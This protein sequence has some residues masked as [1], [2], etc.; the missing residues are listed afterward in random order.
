MA[1]LHAAMAWHCETYQRSLLCRER[2]QRCNARRYKHRE[3]RRML[4]RIWRNDIVD[5]RRAAQRL[6]V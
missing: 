4:A 5:A 1:R 2:A 3:I 6:P